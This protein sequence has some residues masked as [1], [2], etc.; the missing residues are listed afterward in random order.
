MKSILIL[1]GIILDGILIVLG[2]IV[3]KGEC[4]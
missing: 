3:S 1:D 2:K 4:R